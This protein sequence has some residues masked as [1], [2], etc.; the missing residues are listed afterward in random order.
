MDDNTTG[1]GQFNSRLERTTPAARADRSRSVAEWF[2][3]RKRMT[4]E[5]PETLLTARLRLRPWRLGDADDAFKYASDEEWGRYLP[6]PRPY[7]KAH[8]EEFVARQE[9]LAGRPDGDRR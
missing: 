3:G 7:A 1:E 4:G 9:W 5:I 8:A 2:N 6:V